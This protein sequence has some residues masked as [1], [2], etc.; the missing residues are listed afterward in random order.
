MHVDLLRF[1]DDFAINS[2]PP[3]RGVSPFHKLRRLVVIPAKVYLGLILAA[4][5]SFLPRL[6]AGSR[7][8]SSAAFS[9]S[10]GS[11]Q[12]GL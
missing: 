5:C 2:L 7:S 3:A 1:D 12:L 11:I 8:S 4:R 6:I 10:W 9:P